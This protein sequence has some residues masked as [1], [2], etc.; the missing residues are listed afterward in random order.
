[1]AAAYTS[2]DIAARRIG[3]LVPIVAAVLLFTLHDSHAALAQEAPSP[4]AEAADT[5]TQYPVLL[6]NSY[7]SLNLGYI[8]YGFTNLQLEPG[9]SAESIETPRIAVRAVLIG[10]QFH[11]YLSVQ[12]HYARPVLY[13]SY[14][15]INGEP[16]GHHVWMHFGGVTA[17]SQVTLSRRLSAYG[18]G[19]LG[20]TS[21]SGFEEGT[22][23]VV[24]DA[25]FANLLLGTGI[26]Y[27]VN[28]KWDLLGGTLYSQGNTAQNQPATW[29]TSGGFRYTM[30]ERPAA[31]VDE[32]RRA[33]YIFPEHIVQVS[34]TTDTFGYGLNTLFSKKIPIFW[35]GNV[36]VAR[37]F[38]VHYEQNVFHTRKIFGLDVGGSAGFWRSRENAE[39]FRTLSIYPLF[40]FT[41][42]RTRPADVYLAYS[43]AG[44]S[45]ISKSI[46]DGRATGNAFTFQDFMAAGVFLGPR[47]Q[48]NIGVKINHYSNGNIFTENAGVK[49]PYTFNLGYTF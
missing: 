19:G 48:F 33:G 12:A 45:Y 21:R 5:R 26:E 43:L 36:K 14:H 32:D 25:H 7:F 28:Q 31:V 42:W 10:H 38:A 34:Y 9:F 29:F 20:L 3:A 15:T 6:R 47:R 41:V 24:P 2:F 22:T 35:G 39:W 44:P 23:P 1:M 16:G 11:R 46:L 8:D 13:A 27:H 40:R 17:K 30:H 4:R 37:G 49:I 18:E